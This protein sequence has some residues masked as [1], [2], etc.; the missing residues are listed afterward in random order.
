MSFKDAAAGTSQRTA[1][2]S[3]ASPSMTPQHSTTAAPYKKVYGRRTSSAG[4]AVSPLSIFGNSKLPSTVVHPRCA[5]HAARAIQGAEVDQAQC[6]SRVFRR[7][8]APGISQREGEGEPRHAPLLQ[9]P[10][11]RRHLARKVT[12][13]PPPSP[14][15]HKHFRIPRRSWCCKSKGTRTKSQRSHSTW[16]PDSLLGTK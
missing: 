5:C 8:A 9:F 10:P 11:L 12:A 13:P 3:Q 14:V 15:W 6:L 1:Q 16:R 7:D 4:T 2:Q